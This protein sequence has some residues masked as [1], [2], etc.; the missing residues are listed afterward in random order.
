MGSVLRCVGRDQ[1][2]WSLI[3]PMHFPSP[4]QSIV[5][6]VKYF[7]CGAL[8]FFLFF[9]RSTPLSSLSNPMV[10]PTHLFYN[11]SFYSIHYLLFDRHHHCHLCHTLHLPMWSNVCFWLPK[12]LSDKGKCTH[13]CVPWTNNGAYSPSARYRNPRNM[14]FL[15]TRR[16]WWQ[17]MEWSCDVI[18]WSNKT[19]EWPSRRLL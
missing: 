14:G 9:W 5:R 10:P 1:G 2:L 3:S 16:S 18:S 4:V 8:W 13:G 15:M 19:K 6:S 7:L 11:D 17:K 12:R